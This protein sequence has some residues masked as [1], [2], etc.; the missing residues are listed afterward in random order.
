M[1]KQLYWELICFSVFFITQLIPGSAVAGIKEECLRK[2]SQ[3]NDL[4]AELSHELYRGLRRYIRDYDIEQIRSH[5]F[6]ISGLGALDIPSDNITSLTVVS[7]SQ[8]TDDLN[9]SMLNCATHIHPD[10]IIIRASSLVYKQELSYARFMEML[11]HEYQHVLTTHPGR[12]KDDEYVPWVNHHLISMDFYEGAT[13]LQTLRVLKAMGLRPL[14]A[15]GY[16]A[17]G[18]LSAFIISEIVGHEV[19]SRAYYSGSIKEIVSIFD[20]IYG[21]GSLSHLI[22]DPS[23]FNGSEDDLD[24]ISTLRVM[25]DERGGNFASILA[26]AKKLGIAE[27]VDVFNDS[28]A[29]GT[30]SL[31][32]DAN[33]KPMLKSVVES[34]ATVS[35]LAFPLRVRFT[36]DGQEMNDFVSDD[37]Y[38]VQNVVCEARRLEELYKG[39]SEEYGYKEFRGFN[40]APKHF[41]INFCALS[42]PGME[43]M[44]REYEK[45]DK[46]LLKQEIAGR[47]FR[48]VEKVGR[49]KI[50]LFEGQIK[51][52]LKK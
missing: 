43:E 2:M 33:Y 47:I 15:Y 20:K 26:G 7:D 37:N 48:K 49:E 9:F 36:R 22:R 44:L 25:V 40:T 29:I 5:I 12:Q 52:M 28:A 21:Q 27:R 18:T 46:D 19:F 14:P 11:V 24:I 45:A 16:P 39:Y 3:N 50:N 41:S 4:R 30:S 38:F 23:M 42:I 35:L 51:K 17:G 32:F 13:E 8:W 10:K 6:A 31:Y 1:K 34:R